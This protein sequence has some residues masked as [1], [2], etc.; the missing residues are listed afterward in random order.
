MTRSVQGAFGTEGRRPEHSSVLVCP[1]CNAVLLEHDARLHCRACERIWPIRNG[2]PHFIEEYPY[3]GD[4]PQPHMREVLRRAATVSWKEA[5]TQSPEGS[6]QRAAATI[7]NLDR[8]N[9]CHLT[10]IRHGG[11]VLDVGA[12]MGTTSHALSKR[13]SEVVALEPVLEAVEFMRYRFLQERLGNVVCVRGSVWEIPFPPESFDLVVLNGVLEWVAAGEGRESE[14]LAAGGPRSNIQTRSPGRL[15]LPGGGQP[16]V[17]A[18]TARDTGRA[19]RLAVYC[20][21]AS[22]TGRLVREQN[23][24]CWRLPELHTLR[25]RLSKIAR[26]GGVR[27]AAV[28]CRHTELQLTTLLCSAG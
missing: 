24:T 22:P 19:M 28:L 18:V 1:G 21:P 10:D 5:L 20:H 15:C 17:V 7:F 11:R 27:R 2:V 8:A 23:G 6:V 14:A 13:F 16:Y 26:A 9:W 3:C 4:I 12:G 25:P